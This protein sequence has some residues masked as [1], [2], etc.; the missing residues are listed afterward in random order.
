MFRFKLG[1]FFITSICYTHTTFQSYHLQFQ[2]KSKLY[3]ELNL[4]VLLYMAMILCL[5][6]WDLL[7]LCLVMS[8]F[9]I[10]T[11]ILYGS[12]HYQQFPFFSV[13]TETIF[14]CTTISI[15]LFNCSSP[16]GFLSLGDFYPSYYNIFLGFVHFVAKS[17]LS[18]FDS[19][20]CI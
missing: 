8:L 5:S 12:K 17:T 20:E 9:S 13:V 11:P 10:T 14:A 18:N 2:L 1:S 6:P 7:L 19:V 3:A 4:T 15:S 16:G